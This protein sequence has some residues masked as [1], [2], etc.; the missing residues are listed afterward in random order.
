MSK[1]NNLL[2]LGES[3]ITV[4]VTLDDLMQ[5]AHSLADDLLQRRQAEQEAEETMF[6]TEQACELLQ[7]TRTTLNRWDKL[8]YL[9]KVYV[10]KRPRYRKRDIDRISKG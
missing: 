7:V 2:A 1:I 3:N 8:G 5:F 6:T 10:G 4:A 9:K